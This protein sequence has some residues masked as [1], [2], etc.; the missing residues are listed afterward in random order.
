L[1][2]VARLASK[3]FAVGERG[4]WSGSSNALGD[5]ID[6]EV[7]EGLAYMFWGRLVALGT[8]A[9]GALLAVPLDRSGLYVVAIVAF[10][11]LNA[12]SFGLARNSRYATVATWLFVV[13]DAAVLTYIFVTPSPF[14]VEG[15]TSQLNLRLPNF[16]YLGVFLVSMALSYSP[17]LVVWSGVV[18]IVLWNIAYCWIATRPNS[19]AYGSDLLN[20]GV[21]DADIIAL[22]LDPRSVSLINLS[23]QTMFLVLVT[24]I[25][26]ISVW[27]S[28]RLVRSQVAAEAQR[29]A[30]S[31]Y[32]SPN[33]VR[34]LSSVSS[35]FGEPLL[36]IAAILFAD[37]VGFT[38]ISERLAPAEL[39]KLL[40]EFHARLATVAF[41]HGGTVD[42]YIGDEIMVHFGTPRPR[43]DDAA[44]ALSCARDMLEQV[45]LWNEQRRAR[46]EHIIEVGIGVH[47]GEVIAGNIGD[48]RRLEY[49]VLGDTVNVASR[50]E[51]LT[52]KIG[53]SLAVSEDLLT[54]ARAQSSNP[55]SV[56]RGLQ[57]DQVRL[58]RGR[59]RPIAVWY[60]PR[61]EQQKSR[62][63]PSRRQ[64][65]VPSEM[66][67]VD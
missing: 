9:A 64:H 57:P 5:A 34:E 39:V 59:R 31:R 67:Q 49:T 23:Y 16:L 53:A 25:L 41:A 2:G 12:V 15:W 46:G 8:L 29:S 24:V 13:V 62:K 11:L 28:R 52:R 27:R 32:F 26:A 14:A 55:A 1:R 40:K 42:K 7:N 60:L 50:L 37:I 19:I 21:S 22:V 43:P 10:A 63:G 48:E 30:L 20:G 44:R 66:E 65:A 45:R 36:Q 4:A 47:Y 17:A 61:T 6:R 3:R 56:V 58:V 54:A 35:G 51:R 38:N 33:I 18:T